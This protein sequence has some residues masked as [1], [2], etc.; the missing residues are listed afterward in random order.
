MKA[1]R[2]L[3]E[4]GSVA[5]AEAAIGQRLV[6]TLQPFQDASQRSLAKQNLDLSRVRE[7]WARRR[8]GGRL[9]Q[10]RLA[11]SPHP[12]WKRRALVSRPS[13]L[14]AWVAS[15]SV[16]SRSHPGFDRSFSERSSSA[17]A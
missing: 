4:L 11:G 2:R 3:E 12:S 7:A 9:S 6:K 17:P 8:I 1:S 13:R 15:P 14:V 16:H 10:P 5:R